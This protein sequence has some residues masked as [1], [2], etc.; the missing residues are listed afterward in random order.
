MR[1]IIMASISRSSSS[2]EI[3]TPIKKEQPT[4]FSS[5]S[6]L[7]PDLEQSIWNK[8]INHFLA[9]LLGGSAR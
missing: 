7:D 4:K 8:F 9:T 5:V 6:V 3:N 2:V 1:F